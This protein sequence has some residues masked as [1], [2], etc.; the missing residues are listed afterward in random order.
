MNN[1][2]IHV[3]DQSFEKAVVQSPLPALV[4]FWAPWCGPC[5]V[6]APHLERLAGEYADKV[7]VAKVNTD[8]NL[9]WAA[10]FGVQSIPTLVFMR[11][12]QEVE[13]L[14]GA[15]PYATL[16]QKVDALLAVAV[17]QP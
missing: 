9:Q 17:S 8:D 13:R 1:S 7:L 15:V 2:P 10:R 11:N 4:D 5:R 6:V 3:D 14:V 12:G 16:K